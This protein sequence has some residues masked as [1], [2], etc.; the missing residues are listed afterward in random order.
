M[1]KALSRIITFILGHDRPEKK[2]PV[3]QTYCMC[4]AFIDRPKIG[5]RSAV[6]A[7]AGAPAGPRH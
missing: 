6:S 4:G 2:N 3:H 5:G 7:S 1:K